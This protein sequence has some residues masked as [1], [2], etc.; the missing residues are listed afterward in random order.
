MSLVALTVRRDRPSPIGTAKNKASVEY[1]VDD[2]VIKQAVP[3]L[4]KKDGVSDGLV[5]S[6]VTILIGNSKSYL[7]VTET[8]TDIIALS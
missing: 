1:A 3:S 4:C 7:W 6:K 8:V 2:S 5:N